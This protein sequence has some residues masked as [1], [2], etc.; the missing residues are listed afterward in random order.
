MAGRNAT[1]VRRADRAVPGRCLTK[2]V[3]KTPSSTPVRLEPGVYTPGADP[4]RRDRLV[5]DSGWL[6]VALLR[7]LG[8]AARFVS[9]YLVQLSS[10]NPADG[11]PEKDFT[12]LHAWAEVYLPGAGGSGLDATSGLFAGEGHIPLSATPEPSDSAPITGTV[13]PCTSSMEF[14]NV[15]RRFREPP[16]TTLPYADQ[17]WQAVL[18]LGD[19][20]DE[21]LAAGDVRLTIGG[22]PTFVAAGSDEEP[23]W[24]TAADGEQKR[25]MAAELTQKLKARYAPNGV[26]HHGQGKWYP[27]EDLPRWQMAITWRKDGEAL[28]RDASLLGAPWTPVAAATTSEHA[29]ALA[30]ARSAGSDADIGA[31][32]GYVLPAYEDELAALVA[33]TREPAGARP[34]GEDDPA[35]GELAT[36]EGRD[37]WVA[38]HSE[39]EPAAVGWVLPLHRTEEGERWATVAWRFRRGRLVLIPGSS[40]VGLRLPLDSIAWTPPPVRPERAAPFEVEDELPLVRCLRSARRVTPVE[41][42]PTTALA[43]EVRDGRSYVFLPPLDDFTDAIE[44]L[45]AIEGAAAEIGLPVILEGYQLPGDPRVSTISVAPDPGVIEVNVHPVASWRELVDVTSTLDSD[46]RAVG[47]ATEKFMLDGTHTGTG[48]GSHV[49]LGGLTPADSPLLRRPDLLV[50][51]L[52][53]FQHHPSLSYLFS[54]RFIGPTSQAPRVDEARHDS[55]YELEIAFDQLDRVSEEEEEARPWYVDRALRHLLVDL[56][57]QRPL[58]PSSASTSS[59]RRTPHVAAS[60]C[61]SCAASRCSRTR[62]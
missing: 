51:L 23:E 5:R 43:V 15:V 25:E 14:S 40:P 35:P 50:S 26:V 39:A 28:W 47:L 29:A 31:E 38:K 37:E 42:A 9:G 62:S 7:E 24:S 57:D 60:V 8:F 1:R 61:L 49:T 13:D 55:L 19:Q 2:A 41:D 33:H 36:P 59:T 3:S 54:G 32:Q 17:Q 34:S 10:D 46:A 44:L 45:V 52:T 30:R 48:G 12:D 27:G 58:L 21:A 18:E 16:R 20:V 53:Y 6:L 4:A 11:G 56:T 22:E